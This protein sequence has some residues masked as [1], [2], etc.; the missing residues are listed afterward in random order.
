[1]ST[2]NGATST[3]RLLQWGGGAIVLA[4][5]AYFAITLIH[6]NDRVQLQAIKEQM[7]VAGF[8]ELPRLSV[9]N[10]GPEDVTLTEVQYNN[11]V[12]CRKTIKQKLRIGEA[13]RD[14]VLCGDELVSVKIT[15]DK[16]AFE[17]TW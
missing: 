15:T 9:I 2:E 16:G 8:G 12:D 7:S 1:M 14:A 10:K 17:F 4:I 3:T 6:S 5:V 11:R 13:Y